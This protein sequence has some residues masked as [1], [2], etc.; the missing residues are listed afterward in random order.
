M[1]ISRGIVRRSVTAMQMPDGSW[2]LVSDAGVVEASD[3]DAVLLTA[4]R[5]AGEQMLRTG[6]V[7]IATELTFSPYSAP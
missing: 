2:L 7:T 3:V 5:Q 1:S 6:D 4:H